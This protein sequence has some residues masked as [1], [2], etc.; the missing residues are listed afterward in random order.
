[1]NGLTARL[2]LDRLA[3]EPGQTRAV[4]GAAGA[5]GGYATQLAR[6]EGL[7][8]VAD[9]APADE[10]LVRRTARPAGCR[11]RARRGCDGDAAA[12]NLRAQAEAGVLTL[13][14][15]RTMPASRA[16]EAHRLLEAGGVPG[17]LVLEF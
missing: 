2:A 4:T 5:V 7:H 10:Q 12:A 8:V 14:V 3:L 9:A 17:R 13:R 11:G 16:T 15:A 1:M 6:A